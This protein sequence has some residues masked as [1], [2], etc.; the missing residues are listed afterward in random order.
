MEFECKSI[1]PYLKTE[2][3]RWLT[4]LIAILATCWLYTAFGSDSNVANEPRSIF[5]WIAIQWRWE[6]YRYNWVMLLVSAYLIY[7]NRAE[8]IQA[9]K[10]P[11]F[12]GILVVLFSLA[13]HILGFRTQLPRLSLASTIGVFWGIPYAIW[14]W[15][16]A[17]ILFFPAAYALLCFCGSL[18]MNITMPLRLMSCSVACTFLHGAGIEA[19]Q[20]GTLVLSNA[21]GGFQ[22]D[23]ADACSGL[24]SLITM[25]ALTAPYAYVTLTG[26]WPRI[27]LFALSV[28]L[29]MLANALRIFSLGL[30]A[31]WIG[32]DLA[33][34]LYHDLSGY[35]IFLL[36]ILLLTLTGTLFKINWRAKLCAL[37]SQK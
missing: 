12:L 20:R 14:G 28:P 34:R 31:E 7:R 6:D 8:L 37:K 33:M 18:L 25:T 5:H 1:I 29:A 22:F 2:G 30:V 23:V 19:V 32:M 15:N 26:F 21:G 3:G 10:K 11:S 17:R 4:C 35:L 36:S 13:M 16:V 24:R 27:C 9:E